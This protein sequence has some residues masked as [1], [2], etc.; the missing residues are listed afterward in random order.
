MQ[1]QIVDCNNIKGVRIVFGMDVVTSMLAAA[2]AGDAE[3]LS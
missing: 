3:E 2:A 1:I